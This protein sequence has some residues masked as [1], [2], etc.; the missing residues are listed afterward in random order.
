MNTNDKSTK[1]TKM[2]TNKE[3]DT[4]IEA[5]TQR[6]ADLKAMKKNLEVEEE[7]EPPVEEDEV[8]YYMIRCKVGN[9]KDGFRTVEES[10]YDDLDEAREAFK[11]ECEDLKDCFAQVFLE[12]TTVEGCEEILEMEDIASYEN[13]QAIQRLALNSLTVPVLKKMCKDAGKKGY[14]KL[15]KSSLIILLVDGEEWIPQT[16]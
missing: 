15:K 1:Q 11:V 9:K 2:M 7:V 5:L 12:D 4:E 16:D 6:L 10:Q 14:S 8:R 13:K 3:I